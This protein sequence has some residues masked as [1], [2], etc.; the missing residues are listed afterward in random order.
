MIQLEDLEDIMFSY[1]KQR[2]KNQDDLDRFSGNIEDALN[3]A[4]HRMESVLEELGEEN[5]GPF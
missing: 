2:S 4:I 5:Y 3:R 1:L